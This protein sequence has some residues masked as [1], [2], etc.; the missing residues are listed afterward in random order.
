[1]VNYID[2]NYLKLNILPDNINISTITAT[3]CLGTN[4]N[5]GN[6]Y[7]Y[8]K[9]DLTKIFTVKYKNRVRSLE[10]QKKRK[11]RKIVFKI[12]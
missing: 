2:T 7:K 6:I 10:A 5:L 1:M 4:I 12:K 11:K 9:L 3:C 8:M